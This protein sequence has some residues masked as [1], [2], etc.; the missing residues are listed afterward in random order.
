[1]NRRYATRRSLS[2]YA[3]YNV[4][5]VACTFR[6]DRVTSTQTRYTRLNLRLAL[7]MH[8]LRTTSCELIL[9]FFRI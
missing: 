8:L 4:T 6:V 9:N 3:H 7:T 5:R 1:M 2:Q